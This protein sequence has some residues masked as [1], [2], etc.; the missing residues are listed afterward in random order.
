MDLDLKSFARRSMI[1]IA[2]YSDRAANGIT[3]LAVHEADALR[4]HAA[5]LRERWSV[6]RRA[7]S[8]GEMI[9]DQI[10]L[11]PESRNRVLRDQ[12]VRRQLWRGLVRDL[13]APVQKLG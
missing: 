3:L 4:A 12:D 13:L 8:T 6:A 10:D 1:W 5:A 11:L 7:R 9:R 2:D